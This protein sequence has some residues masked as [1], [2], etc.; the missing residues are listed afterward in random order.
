MLRKLSKHTDFSIPVTYFTSK[1]YRYTL[2]AGILQTTKHMFEKCCLFYTN[3]ICVQ[4][5]FISNSH[6]RLLTQP[7]IQTQIKEN[8]KAPRHWPLCGEFTV[9]RWIPHTNGQLRRKCFH[10]MTSSWESLVTKSN[11]RACHGLIENI[12]IVNLAYSSWYCL[13]VDQLSQSN[14]S[15]QNRRRHQH[16]WQLLIKV[17]FGNALEHSGFC[18][19]IKDKTW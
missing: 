17:F 13:C 8:I 16:L 9:D 19:T 7:F 11:V 2:R 12:N 6:S 10:L 1:I 4:R 5:S 14:Q 3:F 18:V 15:D